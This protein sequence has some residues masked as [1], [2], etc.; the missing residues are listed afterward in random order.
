MAETLPAVEEHE[1]Q[2]RATG[3]AYREW[4]MRTVGAKWHVRAA[5]G[6]EDGP[7]CVY[8]DVYGIS[9]A[10]A[11][12]LA[13]YV[14]KAAAYCEQRERERVETLC[15]VAADAWA[16]RPGRPRKETHDG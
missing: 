3:G 13:E 14:T 16:Q 4:L 11:Y 9:P 5:G 6:G 12:R 8:A 2:Y 10:E 1:G 7:W 15:A